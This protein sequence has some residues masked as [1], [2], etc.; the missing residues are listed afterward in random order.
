M[1]KIQRFSESEVF[2]KISHAELDNY[3][4]KKVVELGKS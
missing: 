2:L 3:E 4:L 1:S